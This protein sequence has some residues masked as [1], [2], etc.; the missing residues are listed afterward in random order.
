MTPAFTP[1]TQ[2]KQEEGDTLMRYLIV[3][4]ATLALVLAACEGEDDPFAADGSPDAT[5][6][7]FG[8]PTGEAS[9]DASPTGSPDTTAEGSPTATADV[10]PGVSPGG[11]DDADASPTGSPGTGMGND[12]CEDAFADV[13][14]LTRLTSLSEF[15]QALEALD[16]TIRSCDSVDEWTEQAER[17]LNMSG[18][19][20]DAEEF[21]RARCA[22]SDELG[23]TP[24]CEDL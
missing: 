22:N 12:E 24:L 9:P 6:D 19:D 16:E 11:T 4:L 23:D 2:V 8:S 10:S 14:D 21:L 13:P 7:L 18:L 1:R 15:N 5:L 20:L 3:L 17:Q